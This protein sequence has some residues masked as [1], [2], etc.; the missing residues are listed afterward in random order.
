MRE[1]RKG[2]TTGGKQPD[3]IAIPDRADRV[4]DGAAFCI[5]FSQEG[6]QHSN[7]EVETFEEIEANPQYGDQ[8]KPKGLEK[9][10]RHVLPLYILILSADRQNFTQRAAFRFNIYRFMYRS[11]G[12]RDGVFLHEL[13]HGNREGTVDDCIA[14]QGDQ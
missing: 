6:K 3:F 7:A 8:D 12:S 1:C 11:V 4:Y 2:R 13:D 14:N 10:V 9:F 5:S